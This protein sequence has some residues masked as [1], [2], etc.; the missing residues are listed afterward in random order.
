M[1]RNEQE[2]YQDQG[3]HRRKRK[4][5]KLLRKVKKRKTVFTRATLVG[6]IELEVLRAVVTKGATLWGDSER[7]AQKQR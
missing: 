7:R 4:E 1:I 2:I 5:E 3:N 6:N